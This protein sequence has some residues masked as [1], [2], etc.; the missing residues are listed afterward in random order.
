M[1]QLR[2][3]T[4]AEGAWLRTV[5]ETADGERLRR[6]LPG[7]C[8]RTEPGSL[9]AVLGS[10]GELPAAD[11]VAGQGLQRLLCTANALGVAADVLVGPVELGERPRAGAGNGL[12]E[13]VLVRIGQS[14]G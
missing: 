10:H 4:E 2:S 9:L 13:Q 7:A 3:A 12:T 8:A 6:L 14:G 11:L 5:A 1:P